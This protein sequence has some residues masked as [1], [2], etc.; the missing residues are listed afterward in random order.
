MRTERSS[1]YC[2]GVA[3]GESVWK[4]A[5]ASKAEARVGYGEEEEGV[6][7]DSEGREGFEPKDEGVGVGVG[8]GSVEMAAVELKRRREV[9]ER[10]AKEEGVRDELDA[11]TEPCEKN[12]RE[13][14][15]SVG[16]VVDPGRYTR[17][18]PLY[19]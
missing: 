10:G 13:R 14:K 1:S 9:A 2:F 3:G 7:L 8:V 4:E 17:R 6:D 15:K 11:R 5:M 19:L 18:D 12:E 16:K